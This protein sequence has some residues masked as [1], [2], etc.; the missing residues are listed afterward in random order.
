MRAVTYAR[1]SKVEARKQTVESVEAQTADNL[2]W[3]SEHHVEVIGSFQD[4][5]TASRFST[6]DRPG[7][8]QMMRLI[9]DEQPDMVIVTE[10][11]RLDRQLWNILELI[12]LARTSAFKNIVKT[13]DDDVIDLSTEGGINRTIDQANRDRHESE[14][15]SQ[16]VKAKKRRQAQN[17]EF[18]GGRRPF[19]Y[20]KDGTT[21]VE[22]EAAIIR[23]CAQRIIDGASLSGLTKEL[24]QR[25]VP[26]AFGGRWQRSTLQF[27]FRNKRIIGVRVHHGVE[28]ESQWPAIISREQW[29]QIQLI[30]DAKHSAHRVTKS[31][32]TYLL[33][34]FL[35]CSLCG[36]SLVG[37]GHARTTRGERRIE[38]RY[39]CRPLDSTGLPRGCGKVSRLA[40]PLDA[41]VSRAVIY[42]LDAHGFAQT[43]AAVSQDGDVQAAMAEYQATK[44]QLGSLLA[45]YYLERN[46]Y[47]KDEMLRLKV[48]LE[49]RLEQITR[50]MER[51]DSSRILA[52]V[53]AGGQVQELWDGADQSVQRNLISLLIEKVTV[54]PLGRDNTVWTD[55][56]SGGSWRFDPSKIQIVW[57]V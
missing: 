52:A 27:I 36:N 15:I 50:K 28:Y 2:A 9:R 39:Y 47:A 41:L 42:R 40:E 12:E 46:R 23:A 38:R 51:M 30:L 25:G 14:L 45:D 21:L 49:A 16:R 56:V 3:A 19:G 8:L 31:G 10:Q 37:A 5:L 44:G 48:E 55:E 26:T 22:S 17:G 1:L 20:A 57:R 4:N 53:P 43:F 32:R 35:F 18:P 29:D 13:R 33:T 54:L 34:G 11:S 7:F 6:K 24:N